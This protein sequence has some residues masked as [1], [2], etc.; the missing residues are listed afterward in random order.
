LHDLLVQHTGPLRAYLRLHLDP[1]LRA[2]ESCSDM[3]QSVFRECLGELDRFE[4]RHE[5]AFRKWLFQKALSKVVDRRRY[6]LADKRDPR[7]VAGDPIEAVPAPSA[8]VSGLAIRGE[9]LATLEQ[10]FEELPDEYRRVIV[11]ARLVGQS[12]AEIA[13]EMGRSVEAVGMLLH[14]ALARLAR[15]MHARGASGA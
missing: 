4:F 14:R 11:A 9:D 5:A 2:R 8:S 7:Q 3:V 6:W 15:L 12:H 10:C 13:A 1:L